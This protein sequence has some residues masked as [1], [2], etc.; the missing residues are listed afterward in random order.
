MPASSS[1]SLQ[2][3]ELLPPQLP[4]IFGIRNTSIVNAA[5][6]NFPFLRP[7]MKSGRG[8]CERFDMWLCSRSHRVWVIAPLNLYAMNDNQWHG[9]LRRRK[10]RP[11][12]PSVQTVTGF[13]MR[14]SVDDSRS[15][16]PICSP[17]ATST[18]PCMKTSQPYLLSL[19]F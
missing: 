13:Q 6:L 10:Q 14:P 8:C 16:S 5:S 19:N 18:V 7:S 12:A 11:V 1:K 3:G 2:Q 9:N 17:A 15:N 4:S